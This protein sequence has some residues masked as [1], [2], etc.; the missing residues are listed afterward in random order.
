MKRDGHIFETACDIETIKLAMRKAS[1]GKRHHRN[2]ARVLADPD[3]HAAEIRTM[4]LDATFVPS[5][6]KMKSVYDTT[7]GK[8]RAISRPPFYPDQVVHWALMLALE[9][10]IMRGMYAHSCGSIP[11]RGTAY[12]QK[13]VRK[14]LDRYPR[15][16]KYCLKM[17][18][19]KF[20][21]SIKAA[22]LKAMF[23]RKVKDERCLR[24]VDDIIDSADGLPIGYYTSQWFANFFLEDLDHFI[25]ERLAVPFY[26]RYID[27][28][29]MFGPNKRKLHRARVAITDF[30][31]VKGLAVKGD[32]QVFPT[33]KRALDFLGVR[34]FAD[35]TIIRKRTSLRIRRRVMAIASKSRLSV[36]DASA[37]VSYWGW[38]KR[39]DSYTFYH[40]VVRPVVTIAAARRVVSAHARACNTPGL[41]P[42]DAV[43]HRG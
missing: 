34:F 26:V 14:W 38:M 18:V 43:R 2:V 8:T 5:T 35:R 37:I 7:S 41:R 23:R 36:R 4:L 10:V 16:T 42:T 39:T 31:A 17:D 9:P 11:G 25:K 15:R 21:P 24:L 27:D 3:R 20:Y 6:P 32:W 13:L 29:V 40:S 22:P 33:R 30:L 19:A 12:G 28:L 1:L